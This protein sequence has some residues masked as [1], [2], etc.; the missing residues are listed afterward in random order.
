MRDLIDRQS[1][2]RNLRRFAPEHFN[3]LVNDLILK[4][5]SAQPDDQF[6]HD[7]HAMFDHIWDCEIDH[8]IFQDTVGDLMMAVIQ[9]YKKSENERRR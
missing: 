9:C 6:E 2:L 5:P 3:A 7:I 8:P 4:E 1:L